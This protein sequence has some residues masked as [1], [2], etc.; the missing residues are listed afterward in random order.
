MSTLVRLKK[1]VSMLPRFIEPRVRLIA[2]HFPP[3]PEYC[4]NGHGMEQREDGHTV[5]LFTFDVEFVD[6]PGRFKVLMH[7][8][9]DEG[10]WDIERAACSTQMPYEL[11]LEAA[12][13]CAQ[14]EPF[15]DN[16]QG[17]RFFPS[18]KR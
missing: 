5:S 11:R 14:E 1:S 9:W 2:K 18:A 3:V 12:T 4:D 15:K 6:R 13:L 17:K 7:Y 8:D 10:D 16:L